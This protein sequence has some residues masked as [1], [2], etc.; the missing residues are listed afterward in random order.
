M[1]KGSAP[2]APDPYKTAAAQYQYGT[3]AAN[4]NKALNST[5]TITPYGS[6][7][8]SQGPGVNGG[9]PTYTETQSLSPQ[10]QALFNASTANQVGQAQA[11]GGLLPQVNSATSTPLNLQTNPLG[12]GFDLALA[13]QEAALNPL[14]SQ[15]S[16]QLDSSL[17]NAGAQPGTPAYDNA[18]AAFN[19][20]ETGA[21]TQ[22]A[23]AAENTGLNFAD[24][25]NQARIEQQQLPINEFLSL[26]NGQPLQAPPTQPASQSSV[27]TP[28]IMSAFQNA[29]QGQ[30]NS[31]N[32]NVASSNS[33]MGDLA[34][35][36]A[37]F[38][39]A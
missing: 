35:I 10:E 29:Y 13:G 6:T 15:K 17:R 30:L 32:A 11:A 22:A 24:F 34:T 25:A 12:Q 33:T 21:Y 39:M 36:A 5:N 19:S 4:Y 31:Y 28:D 18:M 38:L 23:G 20:Q 26:S 14:W 8:W 27:S 3:E 7:T 1:G 16:E 9:P 2:Q 37:A